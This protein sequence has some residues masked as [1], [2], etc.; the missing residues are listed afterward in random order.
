MVGRGGAEKETE[1][2]LS[3]SGTLM[4]AGLRVVEGIGQAIQAKQA[5][6]EYSQKLKQ[7]CTRPHRDR[8]GPSPRASSRS[9]RRHP[10]CL[11]LLS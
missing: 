10:T 5:L 9:T 3:R 2:G 8:L 1:G 6:Q 11:F 4:C 7:V